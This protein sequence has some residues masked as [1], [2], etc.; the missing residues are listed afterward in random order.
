M[1]DLPKYFSSAALSTYLQCPYKFKLLYIDRVGTAYKKPQP[2]HSFGNTIH[3]VLA[4]FFK[5]TNL[6]ERTIDKLLSLLETFWISEGYSTKEQE[7]EYKHNAVYLLRNFF[8]NNDVTISPLFTEEFFRVNIEDFYLTGKIDR[9][10]EIQGGVEIID[11]KTGGY[12]LTPEELNEDLQMNIYALCC[13]EKYKLFPKIVSQIFLQH[14]QKVSVIKTPEVLQEIKQYVIDIVRRIYSDEKFLPVENKLCPYC[15]FLI[16]C[17]LMGMGAKIVKEKELEQ[18]FKNVAK[19]LQRAINDL[20]LLNKI[21]LDVSEMMDTQKIVSSIPDFILSFEI[22]KKVAVYLYHEDNKNFVL[23]KSSQNVAIPQII[24]FNTVQQMINLETEMSLL[25]QAKIL[26]PDD[27]LILKNFS[28]FEILFLPMISRERFLG[29]V[30]CSEKKD[31]SNFTNYDISLL[32]SLIN[33]IAVALHNAQLYELAITDGLTKLFI[34]RFFISRLEYEILR[35]QRYNTTFSFLLIDIDHFKQINDTYGHLV[36][37]EVLRYLAKILLS[38]VRITDVVSRYGGEEFA[39]L[40]I[41]CGREWAEKI[42]YRIKENVEKT[43]FKIGD[44]ELHITVSI[45]VE[46]YYSGATVR[47]I[48]EHADKALYHAKKLGRNR[49]VVYDKIFDTQ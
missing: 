15:D 45:G 49:V 16:V 19:Q 30:L 22:V 6:Q 11:Y 36:G 18:D 13:W 20:H 42:A 1:P 44:L 17:P 3:K 33:H 28:S 41:E 8:A 38:S 48:I 7:A 21:S 4:E 34:H 31:C 23:A 5:I 43:V 24:D 40:L 12:I 26:L 29:F 27:L 39:I 46:T 10:D 35:V 2:Y 32:Q 9:I 25:P 14:N 47:E 37:D